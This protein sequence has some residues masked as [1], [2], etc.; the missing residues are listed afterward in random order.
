[1]GSKWTIQYR[2]QARKSVE[3]LDPRERRRIRDFLEIRV[4]GLPNPRLLGLAL[5]G[6]LEGYWRYRVGDYRI[7]CD[8]RDNELI[9][10]VIEIDHRSQIYK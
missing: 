1:M 7:I 6:S 2:K 8:I 9:V 3:R 4:L 5:Q 10:L